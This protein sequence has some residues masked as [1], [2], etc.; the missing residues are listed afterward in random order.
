MLVLM[1]IQFSKITLSKHSFRKLIALV[2]TASLEDQYGQSI[3]AE[4]APHKQAD[5]FDYGGGHVNPNKAITPGLIYDIEISDYIHF[6]CSM[7]YNNSAISTIAGASITC[8]KRTNIQVNLNLPSITIHELKKKMTVSRTVT[9]VGPVNSIY[10][11]RVQT[12]AGVSVRVKPS[13]LLFNSTIK[14]LEFKVVFRSLLKVAGRFSFGNLYWEDG[15]HIVR[16]PL[17]VRTV[18]DDFYAET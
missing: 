16:I 4:G 18:L 3:V 12:P 11:A 13:V 6:L 5:P 17:I 15:F 2:F 10:I 9:N 1:H 7:G 14:K 8:C